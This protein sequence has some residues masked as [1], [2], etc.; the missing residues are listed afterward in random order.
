ME[1]IASFIFIFI[2]PLFFSGLLKYMLKQIH[3][4]NEYVE[5]N[6]FMMARSNMFNFLDQNHN[7]GLKIPYSKSCFF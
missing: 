5:V 2:F 7:L 3:F 1:S 4:Q 6:V